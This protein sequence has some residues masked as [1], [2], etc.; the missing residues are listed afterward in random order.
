MQTPQLPPKSRART[1]SAASK[2][3]GSTDGSV[4]SGSTSGILGSVGSVFSWNKT[5]SAPAP[6][7][8]EDETS[9]DFSSVA[10]DTTRMKTPLG[11]I[12]AN[13]V[14][15]GVEDRE[16]AQGETKPPPIDMSDHGAQTLL[17]SQQI[18]DILNKNDP[19]PVT[20]TIPPFSTGA[21]KPLSAIGAISPPLQ[22]YRP[23]EPSEVARGKSSRASEQGFDWKIHKTAYKCQQYTFAGC[24]C[25]IPV[26]AASPRSSGSH[27]S[28]SF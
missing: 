10:E 17:S 21:M 19:L 22:S 9:R 2:A 24:Y 1:A 6:E 20:N 27:C 14:T 15:R 25:S 13:V 8:A 16:V 18:D 23:Q 12:P 4:K 3:T 26:S 5:K 11:E 7:I 28:C